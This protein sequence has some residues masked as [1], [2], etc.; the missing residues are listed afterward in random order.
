MRLGF[1]QF[2]I[3]I[4]SV[5]LTFIFIG[6]FALLQGWIR[7]IPSFTI[8]II[9]SLAIVTTAV[10]YYLQR[11]QKSKPQEIIQS[12]LLSIM[13]KMVGGCVIIMAVILADRAGAMANAMV[14][15]VGYFLF[16]SIEIFFL[17]K[18]R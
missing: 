8:E 1:P 16:T 14:F 9:L 12:Y 18:G 17:V 7:S 10:F 4:I 11:I 15:F 6:Y 13:V 5:S 2:I 3:A